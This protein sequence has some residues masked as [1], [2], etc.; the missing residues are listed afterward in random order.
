MGKKGDEMKRDSVIAAEFLTENLTGIEGITTKKMFGG[1][2]VF[3]DGKMFGIVDS[4]GQI[5]FKADESSQ[6]VY[7]AQGSHKH[8]RMPYFSLPESILEDRDKLVEWAQRSIE[9]SKG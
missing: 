9:L 1:H 5:F 2:G 4:K 3:H 8:S 6:A 7:E